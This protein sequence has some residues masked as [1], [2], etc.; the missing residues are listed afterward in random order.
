MELNGFNVYID[1]EDNV[2]NPKN[3]NIET[4]KRLEKIISK[5][6]SILYI[7]SQNSER[8]V[9]CPWE[10]G[11]GDGINSKISVLEIYVDKTSYKQVYINMYNCFE[12]KKCKDGKYRC[13]VF[14]RENQKEYVSFDDYINGNNSWRMLK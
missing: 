11:Y 13:F 9:W 7:H 2:L 4:A 10:L 5:S 8:S 12:I 6:K 1:L 14:N 3:V